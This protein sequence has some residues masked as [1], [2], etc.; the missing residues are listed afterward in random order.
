LTSK[1]TPGERAGKGIWRAT[2][3]HFSA[4]DK[5]R[6]VEDGLRGE[7]RI[8]EIFSKEGILLIS[9]ENF[10]VIFRAIDLATC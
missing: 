2:Q 9:N 5:I 10:S 8:A 4:E 1:L 3:R 7:D 6:N